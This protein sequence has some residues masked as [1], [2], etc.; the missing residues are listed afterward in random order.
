[1][2][3]FKE[4]FMR[5][6]VSAF[7]SLFIAAPVVGVIILLFT[8]MHGSRR[9]AVGMYIL[10]TIVLF[11]TPWTK[12]SAREWVEESAAK[13]AQRKAYEKE[14]TEWAKQVRETRA[15]NKKVAG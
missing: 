8:G 15:A 7:L 4:Y 6:F 9:F 2:K 11:F 3:K 12:D 14:R 5:A 10:T 1:M 13:E